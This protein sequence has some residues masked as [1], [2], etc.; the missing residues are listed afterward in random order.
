MTKTAADM[1]PDTGP[2]LI[3]DLAGRFF[4]E[5]V[6]GGS[7]SRFAEKT[8]PVSTR[9]SSLRHHQGAFSAAPAVAM[10]VLAYEQ[11][12]VF[13]HIV[14]AVDHHRIGKTDRRPTSQ[15]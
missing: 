2:G 11:C 9:E 13:E 4:Q 10:P 8:P 14:P 5:L 12:D 6:K 3:G 7:S 15:Q 1:L